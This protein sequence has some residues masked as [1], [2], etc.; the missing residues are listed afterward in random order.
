MLDTLKFVRG[1]VATK[2]LVPVLRY[3]RIANGRIQGQ[4]G[5]VCIDAPWPGPDMNAVVDAQKFLRA[6][7]A[8]EGEPKITEK[9]SALTISRGRFRAKLLTLLVQDY[10]DVNADSI[11]WERRISMGEKTMAALR[12][13]QPFIATDASRPWACSVL[14]DGDKA[15]ATNNAVLAVAEIPEWEWGVV[16]P[17]FFVTEL[18]RIGETPRELCWNDRALCARYADGSWLWSKRTEG[19]WPAT[20]QQLSQQIEACEDWQGVPDDLRE[21]I[22]K[23]R[24][25]FPD[26]KFPVVQTGPE[27]LST[28]EGDSSAAV[29][30]GELPKACFRMES[31]DL[32]AQHAKEWNLEASP[33]PWRGDGIAGLL[34]K[35]IV[36]QMP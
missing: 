7:D 27:G 26:Q 21:A 35:V 17:D 34:S 8:C 23:L 32:V 31:L 9:D 25:F 28:F 11:I 30:C 6:V 4:N 36:G 5:R 13:L 12:A 14:I 16:L 20:L 22:T 2:D 3:F 29:S 18:L 24:P 33:T 19:A 1:A 10:P 15:F